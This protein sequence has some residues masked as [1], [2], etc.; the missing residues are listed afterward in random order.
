MKA[1]SDLRLGLVC[2][3]SFKIHRSWCVIDHRKDVLSFNIISLC[4]YIVGLHTLLVDNVFRR[5]GLYIFEWAR[6]LCDLHQY[7]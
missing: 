6:G 4:L 1:T 2:Q 3:F 7:E 5:D